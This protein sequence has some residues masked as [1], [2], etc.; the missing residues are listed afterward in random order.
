[1]SSMKDEDLL[2]LCELPADSGADV[3]AL[4][5]TAARLLEQWS[6]EGAC[7]G[8]AVAMAAAMGRAGHWSVRSLP[9]GYEGP[10]I[11]HEGWI[12]RDD[13]ALKLTQLGGL[14]CGRRFAARHADTAIAR[15]VQEYW[16]REGQHGGW[17]PGMESGSG[18]KT[19]VQAQPVGLGWAREMAE[20]PPTM[21]IPQVPT[22]A[23]ASTLAA[24]S[25]SPPP[26]ACDS[27]ATSNEDGPRQDPALKN[28]DRLTLLTLAMFDP[29]ILAS[30]A[31]IAEG[32][33]PS[34]RL[35]ERTI[36]PAIRRLVELGLAE[37]PEGERQ[38][39]RLTLRGRRLASK[40]A[41]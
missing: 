24:V 36:T 22:A 9:F 8:A 31:Q 15:A 23:T 37:R 6:R 14:I 27:F 32:M 4:L 30:V 21:T 3:L 18:W 13:L 5:R 12:K 16:L 26:A 1:M 28:A 17:R 10:S 25:S 33:D 34:E 2:K 38:G 19:V 35:S 29:S 11:R 41:D 7:A 39:A 20:S 40:I